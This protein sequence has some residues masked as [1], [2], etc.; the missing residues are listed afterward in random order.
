MRLLLDWAVERNEV[1]RMVA[2]K[3]SEDGVHR[4]PA[5]LIDRFDGLPRRAG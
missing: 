1:G 2:T 5:H 3:V 4:A